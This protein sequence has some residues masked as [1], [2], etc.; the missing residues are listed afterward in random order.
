MRVGIVV[1]QLRR[2]VPGGIGTYTLGLLRGLAKLGDPR[3]EV[4]LL[5]SRPPLSGSDPLS[6]LGFPLATSSLPSALLTRAWDGGLALRPGG[7]DVVHA[8]S[9]GGPATGRVPSV[10]CVHDLAWRCLPETFPPRGRR[11]HEAAL[12]RAL[13]RSTRFV[14]PSADTGAALVDAG[15]KAGT[16]VVVE[17]GCDHLAPVDAEATS[18]LLA[19]LGV[20]GAYLLCVGT[21]EPRK[22]LARVTTA[23]VAARDRLLAPWPLV[24]VGPRGW[25]PG[26]VPTSG[27]VLTGAVAPGV[28]S[29]L[30]AGARCVVYVPLLEGWGLPAVEAMSLGT[31]V[32]ASPMPSTAGRALE[33]DPLDVASIAEGMVEAACDESTR[34]RLSASGLLRA[35]ALTWESTAAAHVALWEEVA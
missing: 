16:V 1:E 14:V 21:L 20:A 19:S 30:Y 25:G 15:A 28:L 3:V 7:W 32:V 35:A 12:A 6:G 24:I 2:G 23:F 10:A 11:W 5:A 13:A 17:E 26:V 34:A 31:P 33:V 27:V 22:N 9:L 4:T 8:V 18:D 29:G